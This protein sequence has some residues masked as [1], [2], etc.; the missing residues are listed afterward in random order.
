MENKKS[1]RNP[2][3]KIL[4][5]FKYEMMH[6]ARI[7]LPIY[8][9][10]LVLA[11]VSG[12][13][14]YDNQGT[15]FDNF[16]ITI[17]GD[18]TIT[19][20]MVFFYMV[21]VITAAVV[22]LTMLTKRFKSGLLEDE[23]YLNLSLPVTIG[24]HLW[25][26]ILSVLVWIIIYI[27]MVIL[28]FSLLMKKWYLHDFYEWAGGILFCVVSVLTLVLFIYLINAI[29]H[30]AKKH[31]SLVKVLAVIIIAS[32]ASRISG[33]ISYYYYTNTQSEFGTIYL[34]TLYEAILSVIFG[35]GTYLILK[36]KLNLE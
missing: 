22:S 35:I 23:A 32:F 18:N 24:E 3:P 20:F 9:V 33:E 10:T 29:A 11:L 6:S 34:I 19:G 36:L 21:L 28:S 14:A 8:V 30:L 1:I 7:L 15:F 26:R 31:R 16:S 12:M 27:F 2:F 5:V 17:P 13:L 25:G 4:K